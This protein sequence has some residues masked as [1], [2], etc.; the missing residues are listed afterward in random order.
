[1]ILQL[2][3]PLPVYVTDTGKGLAH[4]VIDYGPE[5][6]LIWVVFLDEDGECWCVPNWKIRGQW[7]ST[8]G[9]VIE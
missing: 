2:N 4:M 5:H 3:P 9:R 6:D 7:N 8:M 1:M